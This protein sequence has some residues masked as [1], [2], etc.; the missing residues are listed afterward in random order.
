LQFKYLGLPTDS[1]SKSLAIAGNPSPIQGGTMDVNLD[2]QWSAAGV[3]NIDLP[4]NVMLHDVTI[5]LPQAGSS[6]VKQMPI[7]LGLRG[8]IDNPRIHVDDKQLADALAAAGA[9]ALASHVR[10]E[11]D[12]AVQ[13]VA[14]KATKKIGDQV[15]QAIG[16][17]AKGALDN[18]LPG[19]KK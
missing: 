9:G 12:K 4:L 14:D 15:D 7:A 5:T 1:I 2:G 18:L 11:A 3:G 10:G 17:K 13:K 16:D 8:P 6:Q 19:K